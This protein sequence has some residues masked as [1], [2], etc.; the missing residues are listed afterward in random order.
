MFQ[1]LDPAEVSTL[2]DMPLSCDTQGKSFHSVAAICVKSAETQ[3][4]CQF[5]DPA[6]VI[7]LQVV[8]SFSDWYM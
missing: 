1:L 6:V 2:H 8:P 5:L 4:P 3:M 7:A